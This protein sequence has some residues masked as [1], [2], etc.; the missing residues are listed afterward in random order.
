M[1]FDLSHVGNQQL[2]NSFFPLPTTSNFIMSGAWRHLLTSLFLNPWTLTVS[3]GAS[4]QHL[5]A[6]FLLRLQIFDEG[7]I[8]D[9]SR[10]KLDKQTNPR[11][12]L[13]CC[14]RSS[15]FRALYFMSHCAHVEASFSHH[16]H[17]PSLVHCR[18][19]APPNLLHPSL[20]NVSLYF[21]ECIF[22][23]SLIYISSSHLIRCQYRLILRFIGN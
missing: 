22:I 19:K 16:H 10:S 12:H 21:T 23:Q 6:P 5:S 4:R 14:R 9:D 3:R 20:S 18:T 13:H 7:N 8:N 15:V 11:N 1:R 2:V 17:Q